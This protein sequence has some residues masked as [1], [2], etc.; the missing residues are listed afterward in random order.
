MRRHLP[1]LLIS[2]PSAV[3]SLSLPLVGGPYTSSISRMRSCMVIYPRTSIYLL[4]LAFLR[5][6][7]DHYSALFLRRGS[8]EITVLLLYVDDM[9][10]MEDDASGISKLQAHLHRQFEMKSL[11]PLRYF[12]GLEISDTFDG[13]YLSQAKYA[14][15]LLSSAGLTDSKTASTPL[16]SDCRLTPMDGIPFNDPTLYRQLVR[17]LIYLTVTRPD[18]AY[19]VH[20][21]TRSS[22]VLTGYSDADWAGDPS[23]H[24]STTGFCFFLGDSLISWRSK[25]QTVVSRSSA[26]SEYRALA[27]TT[28]ELLWLRW[29][30]ADLG[31]PQSS[32]TIIHC[33]SQ[34]AM[35]I[36]TNDVFHERTKHIEIDFHL[37]RHHVSHCNISLSL[38]PSADYIADGFT[39]PHLSSR[40][41]SFFSKLKLGS[42]VPP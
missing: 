7:S 37:V 20:I 32:A 4:I 22:L 8:A 35:K 41:Q 42:T 39:E 12:L 15:D 2:S 11:G 33:D 34:S 30:L 38:I 17:S 13:Y 16:D 31:V 9:I 29:L 6:L 25:K 26:E 40:F 28:T 1:R 24:R 5:L 10:I 27:D 19:A 36:L 21:V 14:S 3:L 23:D 18:I